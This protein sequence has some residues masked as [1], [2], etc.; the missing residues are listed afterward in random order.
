ANH[1]PLA[2]K[3]RDAIAAAV[4]CLELESLS[5]FTDAVVPTC[6]CG[7]RQCDENGRQEYGSTDNWRHFEPLIQNSALFRKRGDA[8]S[9]APRRWVP[10]DTRCQ[11]HKG[12]S[13]STDPPRLAAGRLKAGS[14]RLTGSVRRN[15]HID[16]SDM[17]RHTPERGHE[18]C[19][20]PRYR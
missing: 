16:Y 9:R 1:H 14:T 5:G 4:Q 13:P 10:G 2:F 7:C 20:R 11:L 6:D 18:E 17:Q 15:H 12:G 3:L 19:A 8:D